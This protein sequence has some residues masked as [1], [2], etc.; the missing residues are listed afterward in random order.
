MPCTPSSHVQYIPTTAA[1][2]TSYPALSAFFVAMSLHP[3]VQ[4]KAQAELDTVVGDSRLPRLADRD[5]LPY[6]NAVVKEL[7]RWHVTPMSV[8]HVNTSD[9][10]S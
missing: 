1:I 10:T 7:L 9:D 5:V 4:R 3:E 2:D 8:P 6:V